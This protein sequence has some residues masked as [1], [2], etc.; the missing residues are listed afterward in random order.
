MGNRQ[1]EGLQERVEQASERVLE[2]SG[3]VGPLDLLQE[4]RLLA[5]SHVARWRKGIIASLAE[6][7]QGSPEKQQKTFCYFEQWAQ[8]R[9]LKPMEIPCVRSTPGGEMPLQV[10]PGGDPALEQFFR[11]HYIPGDL[12]ATKSERIATKLAKPPDIVVFQTVRPSV[13]CSECE[14]EI[15]KG[16]LLFMEKGQP[17]CLSCADLD[18]LEFLPS[19]DATLTRRA[20]QHSRLSAIVVRFARARGRYERQGI[21]VTPEAIEQAE[22]ECLNDEELRAA[23]RA[24]DALRREQ[25]DEGL[26]SEMAESIQRMYPSCPAAEVERIARHTA[27]RGSGRVGRSAAGRNLE[28][29]ALELAV[30]AWVRHNHT[31]YDD[32]LAGGIGRFEAREMVRDQVR[33]VLRR[34]TQGESISSSD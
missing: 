23:R 30:G 25:Q 9:G 26:A 27:E 1:Q 11:T 17:L 20:R 15:L 33:E 7:I 24:R 32:H 6:F 5:P 3:S 13:T 19:G 34:W 4:M 22:Q 8:R 14:V 10:M 29:R 28:D 18:H 21:L 31:K 16:R 2:A 12:P